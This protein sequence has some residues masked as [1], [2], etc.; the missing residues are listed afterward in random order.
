MD[1]PQPEQILQDPSG[2]NIPKRADLVFVIGAGVLNAV[3]NNLTADRWHAVGELLE[4]IAENG[5][6]DIAVSL[7]RG[8]LATRPKAPKGADPVL[9]NLLIMRT[10]VPLMTEARLI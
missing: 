10:M 9:P 7:A 1:L 4:N 6:P 8:W 3:R 5:H 2:L